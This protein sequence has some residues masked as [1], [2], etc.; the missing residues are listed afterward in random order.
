MPSWL[1]KAVRTGCLEA[2]NGCVVCRLPTQGTPL[3][4]SLPGI[5]CQPQVWRCRLPIKNSPKEPGREPVTSPG[6]KR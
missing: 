2:T 4:C 5:A 3:A 1:P 6:N